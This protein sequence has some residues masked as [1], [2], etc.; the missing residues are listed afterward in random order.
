MEGPTC[1]CISEP[2]FAGSTSPSESGIE[3]GPRT[4]DAGHSI[5]PPISGGLA[6]ASDT[7]VQCLKACETSLRDNGVD[8]Q[9][10]GNHPSGHGLAGAG[11]GE[12]AR[13]EAGT[14]RERGPARRRADMGKDFG[15]HGKLTR[16]GKT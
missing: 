9:T 11:R 5:G 13:R 2:N 8:S 12:G 6:Q 4:A 3:D 7:M 14:E 10:S 16:K 1:D 15:R